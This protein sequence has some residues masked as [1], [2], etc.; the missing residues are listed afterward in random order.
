LGRLFVNKENEGGSV[1][2]KVIFRSY[3][4]AGA[5][6]FALV[7]LGTILASNFVFADFLFKFVSVTRPYADSLMKR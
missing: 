5:F 3:F 7:F 6:F 1:C 2:L 4:F